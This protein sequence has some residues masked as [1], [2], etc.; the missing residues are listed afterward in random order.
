MSNKIT[1]VDVADKIWERWS[2]FMKS[3]RTLPDE[4][5]QFVSPRQWAIL[6]SKSYFPQTE[7]YVLAFAVDIFLY[8]LKI[9]ISKPN[10]ETAKYMYSDY[11]GE[12]HTYLCYKHK[13]LISK[14][15][16]EWCPQE[17]LAICPLC[18]VSIIRDNGIDRMQLSM[19]PVNNEIVNYMKKRSRRFHI[20]LWKSN[21][22]YRIKKWFKLSKSKFIIRKV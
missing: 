6:N 17:A 5:T 14:E 4:S 3:K 21:A 2:E 10:R 1:S 7:N 11:L 13:I 15:D 16:R 20:D 18:N 12:Q 9:F 8:E 22:L 19:K